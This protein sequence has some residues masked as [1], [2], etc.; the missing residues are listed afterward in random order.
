MGE[1]SEPVSR[2]DGLHCVYGYGGCRASEQGGICH[3]GC[4]FTM[5]AVSELELLR[6]SIEAQLAP[7]PRDATIAMLTKELAALYQAYVG[8]LESGR[9]RI[10]SLGSDCDHVDVMED[11]DPALRRAR[12]VLSEASA[13]AGPGGGA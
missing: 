8:C 9:D 6:R 10:I 4:S 13:L 12:I 11:G 7:D 5:T 3:P 2:K 1:A